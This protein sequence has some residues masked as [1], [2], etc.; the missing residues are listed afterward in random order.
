M[1]WFSLQYCSFWSTVHFSIVLVG[2]GRLASRIISV[3][4]EWITCLCGPA[5]ASPV[6]GNSSL[7]NLNVLNYNGGDFPG[8][9]RVF[10]CITCIRLLVHEPFLSITKPAWLIILVRRFKPL[11]S[12]PE[13][14][15]M[16]L[17]GAHEKCSLPP[18]ASYD[19][20]MRRCLF[21]IRHAQRV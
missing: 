11:S 17:S 14:H 5:C 13:V 20:T 18:D 3:S 6:I 4:A 9:Q 15:I 12:L 7:V 2:L 10:T 19:G 21:Q 8:I 1:L 16:A